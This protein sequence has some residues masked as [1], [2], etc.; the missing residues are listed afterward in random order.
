MDQQF[1]SACCSAVRKTRREL[2]PASFQRTE[3]LLGSWQAAAPWDYL[4]SKSDWITC[5][6]DT[7][8]LPPLCP[9]L[10]CSA[11]QEGSQTSTLLVLF[12]ANAFHGE[13][14]GRAQISRI[15]PG[16]DEAFTDGR[17]EGEAIF[18]HFPLCGIYNFRL[19]QLCLHLPLT[20]PQP[21]FLPLNLSRTMCTHWDLRAGLR[22]EQTTI[23]IV[24]DSML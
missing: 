23:N 8:V 7:S 1:C 22:E 9:S 19:T 5:G 18:F 17:V 11:F 12:P 20:G 6:R 16:G 13:K 4:Q 24:G 21:S 14:C 10:N 15:D 2:R 3:I